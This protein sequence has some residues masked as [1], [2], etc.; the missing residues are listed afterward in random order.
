[1][2]LAAGHDR[3]G[4]GIK[5]W[6]PPSFFPAIRRAIQQGV[7]GT[8]NKGPRV[9]AGDEIFGVDPA[10]DVP[11][12]PPNYGQ[13]AIP[14]VSTFQG[15][16]GTFSRVYR[17]SD[18]A[19]MDSLENARYMRND[20]GIMEC[21]EARKRAVAL[22]NWHLEPEDETSQDQKELVKVVEKILRRIKRFTQYRET[23]LEAVWYGRYAVQMRYG[24]VNIDGRE[25]AMPAKKRDDPGWCPINGDKLVWRYD[26]GTGKYLTDQVGIRVGQKLGVGSKINQR[27]PVEA[28]DRGMAYFLADW[29]RP[30]ISI[31]RHTVEDGAFEDPVQAGMIH[32]V[33]IRH[34]IYWEWYQ[35]Q[36]ALAFL[37]EYLQRSAGGLEIHYYPSGN[38]QAKQRAEDAVKARI[39]GGK[40]VMLYP[41]EVG[42]D[43]QNYGVE[44]IEPGTA[45]IETLQ[46]LLND[47]FGHRIKRYILGQT[48]STEAASTGLGSG[49]AELHYDSLQQ[50]IR[51][52]AVNLEDTLTD[53][54]VEVVKNWNFPKA[55]GIHLRFRIETEKP[56][57]KEQLEALQVAWQMGA[58]ISERELMD[59]IGATIPG[60]DDEI[61][62]NPEI[63]AAQQQL[64][65][66]Q[67]QAAMA[68]A[69][70]QGFGPG[71]G[72]DGKPKPSMEDVMMNHFFG[73]PGATEPG[74]VTYAAEGG[75]WVKKTMPKFD[76][77]ERTP[78]DAEVVHFARD[79][80]D[81]ADSYLRM[82]P[83]ARYRGQWDESKHP[84]EGAGKSTGGQF[85]AGQ[86]GGG[87]AVAEKPKPKPGETP[88]V[89]KIEGGLEVAKPQV[90]VAPIPGSLGILRHDMPQLPESVVPA[91][92]EMLAAKG[93]GHRNVTMKTSELK[94]T[95]AEM[96]ANKVDSMRNKIRQSGGK[97]LGGP[98][99]LA[100]NDG[101]ILDG[102]HRWAA[103]I[104]EAPDTPFAVI[105][106]DLPIRE[107]LHESHRFEQ[108]GYAGVTHEKIAETPQAQPSRAALQ[109]DPGL[110][111]EFQADFPNVSPEH[112]TSLV[113]APDDARVSVARKNGATV[114][115][116]GRQTTA[117]VYVAKITGR[118]Y[119]AT[120]YIIP[121]QKGNVCC[122]EPRL[123]NEGI[124]V[125]AGMQKSGIGTR[126]FAKQVQFAVQHGF[127][128]IDCVA[129]RSET[130]IGYKFWPKTGYDG[131]F[132]EHTYERV[133]AQF[134]PD[135]STIQK[136][137]DK[138]GGEEW[139]EANGESMHMQFDLHADSRNR[140][141]LDR[142]LR[143]KR[144]AE[145]I[146]E[147]FGRMSYARGE[148][149]PEQPAP[150]HPDDER[151]A[152]EP[153]PSEEDERILD[154]V[155]KEIHE[156][157]EARRQQQ[158]PQ[159]PEQYRRDPW[160]GKGRWVTIG[161]AKGEG[162][163]THVFIDDKGEIVKGPK[164]LAGKGI[165]E[166]GAGEKGGD[167]KAEKWKD[168]S[169]DE[170]LQAMERGESVPAR[171]ISKFP[172]AQ[173]RVKTRKQSRQGKLFDPYT[174]PEPAVKKFP[175]ATSD[176]DAIHK[177]HDGRWVGATMVHVSELNADPKRF[178]YK[179]TNIDP[180]TGVTP[181][182]KEVGEYEPAL[183]GQ[184]LVWHDPTDNKVYVVNGHHR[185]ELASRAP[186]SD[187]WHGGM[188]VY[189]LDAKN[190]KEARA[191]GALA[192]IAEGRGSAVDAAKFFRDTGMSVE[193]VRKRHISI[194]GQVAADGTTL[195]KLTEPIFQRV[196]NGQ[197]DVQRAIA[198][199]EELGDDPDGQA[200]V[201]KSIQDAERNLPREL[202][203]DT[204]REMVEEYADAPVSK[205]KA[206]AGQKKL[207]WGDEGEEDRKKLMVERATIK[208]EINR[209]LAEERGTFKAVTTGGGKRAARLEEAGAGSVSLDV[210]E[211]KRK[212]ADEIYN[213]FA[214]LKNYR[215]PIADVINKAAEDFENEPKRKKS[216]A[217]RAVQEIRRLAA[218]PATL[219]TFGRGKGEGAG[220]GEEATGSG[221]AGAH[222]GGGESGGGGDRGG[223][224]REVAAEE[225]EKFHRAVAAAVVKYGLRPGE[226]E[227]LCRAFR[228]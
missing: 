167:A 94:P 19:I 34:R 216:I 151:Y 194:K 195:A 6:S 122:A 64:Q 161:P 114:V 77:G 12:M 140:M 193:D 57:V 185:Y 52:D 204:I 59:E 101:Y 41:R 1:M 139:W 187:K 79:Y 170:V 190:P 118:G 160:K 148:A 22:L 143:K 33:G 85:T 150:E 198:I 109:M 95:Q 213:T 4:N 45:G 102:H 9:G 25:Y 11:G 225:R 107:L 188:S 176:L 169:E 162:G 13:Y 208:S 179:V 199:G 189:F 116:N 55:K 61:L 51:Y 137:F 30:L 93:I 82:I 98:P 141:I 220:G 54:L 20:V 215:G 56:N 191:W 147:K 14:H 15:L 228:A 3:N 47:Y 21:L 172:K 71:L 16:F 132:D 211:R 184:L 76:T 84:R 40:N 75:K 63:Q 210:A 68:G 129:T 28:T 80:W 112:I 81:G 138:I 32:G 128:G 83:R 18:E 226:V 29:E 103:N 197:F 100:S 205:G 180:E 123:S 72:P 97:G 173:E 209:M 27:W 200:E 7:L 224:G 5:R 23:L 171:I 149:P 130:M 74:E 154:E 164:G 222:G 186:F 135:V 136:L 178:Q 36:E 119:A 65:Q 182:L 175:W 202:S 113:G 62:Q 38:E 163:G 115:I 196:T 60:P 159:E 156:E 181:E 104:A 92:L 66:Q 203:L 2:I 53:D 124:K 131:E 177:T 145:K 43:A 42:D 86:G 8:G 48:L 67:Q 133:A 70:G 110:A 90:R 96:N 78:E 111:R 183:G 37:M 17:S 206:G 88:E 121:E 89:G 144:A 152:E 44:F 126:I 108:V 166:L 134:G 69:Q 201:F 221:G 192:N 155:W 10:F 212:E 217:E 214:A 106:V 157:N 218:D 26:D 158:P 120:R 223:V 58:K 105:Q 227:R 35:K 91:F 31:H 142:Y 99:V 219:G 127:G 174:A 24:W 207:P 146:P 39:A 49:V 165:D 50:I 73:D 46:A 125:Q 87:A 168:A 153:Y 117:K